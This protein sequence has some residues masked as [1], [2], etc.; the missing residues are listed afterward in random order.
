MEF[1]G[2]NPQASE[3]D[4]EKQRQDMAQRLKLALDAQSLIRGIPGHEADKINL[5]NLASFIC[6]DID[7]L[8]NTIN[9]SECF[10]SIFKNAQ[11]IESL[12]ANC[13]YSGQ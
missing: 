11:A 3:E 6:G 1:H 13:K 2:L 12:L 5:F 7:A 9:A 8:D 4:R 10:V